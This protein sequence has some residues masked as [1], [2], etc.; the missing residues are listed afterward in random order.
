MTRSDG[1]ETTERF[2]FLDRIRELPS[3]PQ[4]LV[5]ISRVASDPNSKAADLADVILMDQAMTMK[6]LRIANSAQYA[7]CS[8]R[9]TTVSRAVILLG[10]ESVRAVALGL[11]AFSLLSALKRGGKIHEDFWKNSV[12]S[13]VICQDFA[14]LLG[15]PVAEEAFVAGLL[16]DVG[17]LVLAESDPEKAT[18]VY[19]AGREGPSLLAAEADAF[20]VHHAEVAEELARR[21]EL[22]E[23]LQT[24]L[25]SHHRHFPTL[26]ESRGDKLAFLVGVSKIL[27]GSPEDGQARDV[28]TH[29][30]RLLRKPVG[31]V[32]KV[33]EE[34]PP[35]IEEYAG[36]FEIRLDDLKTYTVWL[37]EEHQRLHER[38]DGRESRRRAEERRAAE[39]AT[40]REVHGL[41]LKGPEPKAA[42]QRVL[43]AAWDC[44]GSRRSIVALVD[45]KSGELRAHWSEGDVTPEFFDDF[46]FPA[47]EGGI[48]TEAVTRGE[49]VNVFDAR[50][51]YF[52][53]LMSPREVELLDAPAFAVIP[54]LRRDQGMGILYADRSERDEAFDDDEVASLVTLAN[55]LSLALP[56]GGG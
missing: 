49:P 8:I 52:S 19:E 46:R 36:Y 37:E 20:G 55:L 44:A 50:L 24:A 53:R 21:W 34:L 54:F 2:A 3:L 40:V 15:M 6:V 10:F 5:G 13:A 26:P 33:L 39:L 16:H 51:P 43:R 56:G 30:A 48:L 42:V 31:M 35:K 38:L 17:K 25:G 4:V 41:I 47:T 23:V 14:K 7:I 32:L 11:G 12:A 22:P 45:P 28:A 9:I 1:G 29:V 27:S 18:A